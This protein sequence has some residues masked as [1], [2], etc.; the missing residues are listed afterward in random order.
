[1]K[2]VNRSRGFIHFLLIIFL[3]I[4]QKERV[5]GQQI[6]H[7]D[8]P[9]IVW[10]VTEDMSSQHLGAYGGTGGKTPV[11]DAFAKESVRYT[12]L[13]S[14]AGVCAPSRASI[15]TGAYQ[16]AIGAQHMRTL[17]MSAAASD[18]YPTGF[19]AYSAMLPEGM[20]G[21]PEYLRMAGYYVTNNAKQDYQFVAPGTLWDESSRKGHWRNRPDKNQPFFS[22]FNIETTHE[23]QVWM[24]ANQPLLVDPAD[25]MI[26]PYYPDD[27]ISR[28]VMARF[29]SNVMT[30]DSQVGEIL[31]QLKEDG[32][33]ENT[34]IF[35]YSDHGDGLPYAKRE[36]YDRGL[37]APLMIKA[38]FLKP[39]TVDAQLVS[40]VDLGPTVLSLAGVEIP[41]TIQGKAFLGKQ[42]SQT[43]RKYIYA[44]RDRMDSEYD[45]V[46]AVSDGRY[47]YIRNYMPEK[48]NYQ[49]VQYR[50]QN[51]LM[52]HLLKLNEEGKLTPDQARWFAPSKPLE[53][54]YDTQTDPYEFKNLVGNPAYEEK[55]KELRAAHEQ[56][57]KDY[58]DMSAIPEMEMVRAWWGGKDEAPATAEPQVEFSAGKVS[59]SSATKGASIGYRK[60]TKDVWTIFQ[61]PIEMQAGDSLYV[62]AHR[63]GFVPSVKSLVL[64]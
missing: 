30:M 51:P 55:L 36:M 12:N 24:L 40:F 38:P 56:W 10:I 19:K 13:F 20:K 3:L 53:E 27:S 48:P 31:K 21:F 26:P 6:N 60:S 22:V 41:E 17:G 49:N 62:L 58:P 28:A 14:T 8:R 45:R 52:L 46:R 34:I 5:N 32:L 7:P 1:M 43:L 18:V 64:K 29:V 11:L 23:S 54:F 47:K 50:L 4:F 42:K 16:T 39:G 61:K 2:N 63:I 59:I 57:M 25:V 9:N 44:G 33:Y 35:F 37:R 15:I